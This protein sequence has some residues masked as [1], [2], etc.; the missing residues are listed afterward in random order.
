ME[1]V[2]H[3]KLIEYLLKNTESVQ[4]DKVPELLEEIKSSSNPQLKKM[5]DLTLTTV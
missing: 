5:V 2:T 1:A 3:E 4:S